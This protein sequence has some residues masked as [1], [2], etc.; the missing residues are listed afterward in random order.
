MVYAPAV[1]AAAATGGVHAC[2]HITGGGIA[3]NLVRALPEGCDAVVRRGA[4]EVPAIFGE[5][6]RLGEVADE[7]MARVFN[8]GLGM[9][10]VAAADS[11]DA[12]LDAL[13]RPGAPGVVVGEVT[14]GGT[15]TVGW[16]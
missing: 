8:L 3:G 5:I 11:T 1:L 15:G 10:L 4:W 6:E 9:V 12:V 14:G 16:R 13:A 2:A 7:E